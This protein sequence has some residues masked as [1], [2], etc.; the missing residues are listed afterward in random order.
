MVYEAFGAAA[1]RGLAVLVISHDIPRVLAAAHR[2][3]VMRH[4]LVIA[5]LAAADT[6]V[7]EVIGLMLGSSTAA[8]A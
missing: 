3:A 1:E 6:S 8:A 5:D 4:G 7:D 2:V